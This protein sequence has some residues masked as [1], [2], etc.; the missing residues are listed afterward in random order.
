MGTHGLKGEIKF[1]SSF[2]YL[3]KVF[4]DG[5]SL[6]LGPN[7]EKVTF[8]SYRNNNKNYLVLLEGIDYDLVR[9]YINYKVY[10]KRK[11]LELDNNSY[12]I[13]DFLNKEAYYNDKKIGIINDITNYGMDNF[14]I[15]IKGQKDLLVPYNKDFIEKVSDKIYF[16]NLEAFIDED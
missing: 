8:K 7:K 11:D 12:V 5:F 9:K 4:K 13:E 1:I 3:S 10:V 2:P 14:V 16:K 6:Y 15:N